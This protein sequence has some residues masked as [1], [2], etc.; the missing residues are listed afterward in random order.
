MP[1][2]GW[3]GA[4]RHLD[5]TALG[6]GSGSWSGG[7][8]THTSPL[9]LHP[10][11]LWAIHSMSSVDS[12]PSPVPVEAPATPSRVRYCLHVYCRQQP[13][14]GS[15]RSCRALKTGVSWGRGGTSRTI[16]S[17]LQPASRKRQTPWS[18]SLCPT[19]AVGKLAPGLATIAIQTPIS[20]TTRTDICPWDSRHPI[21]PPFRTPSAMLTHRSARDLTVVRDSSLSVHHHHPKQGDGLRRNGG[22]GAPALPSNERRG[23]VPRTRTRPGVADSRLQ[24]RRDAHSVCSLASPGKPL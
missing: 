14:S 16:C 9:P 2:G 11:L 12:L 19:D 20:P 15:G 4:P 1:Q 18:L 3:R 13:K 8:T 23:S 7:R 10:P 24:R 6:A 21:I 22:T 5:T 17:S